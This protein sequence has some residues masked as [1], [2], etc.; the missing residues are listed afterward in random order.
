MFHHDDND[1]TSGPLDTPFPGG[2]APPHVISQHIEAA[3]T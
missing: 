3:L 2:T 1:E